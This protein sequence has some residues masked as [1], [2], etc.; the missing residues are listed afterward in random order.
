MRRF[1]GRAKFAALAVLIFVNSTLV[2]RAQG[3]SIYRLP[4][5]TRIRLKMDAEINSRVSS[6]NDTFITF[7]AHPVRN[8]GVVVIPENAVVEGRVTRVSPASGGSHAGSLDVVF[9]TLKF[10][11]STRSID[12]I[13]TKPFRSASSNTFSVLSILG[14]AAAGALVGAANSPRGVLIGAGV[15]A[16][17][18]T[19]AALLR[20]GKDVKIR[21]G[22]EF[23]IEL[24]K[25][26][27]LPVL[28]Y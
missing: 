27:V 1:G 7:V 19:G 2:V 12:G 13:A 4:A 23:E 21:R 18:G 24:K 3:D 17:A 9:E 8:R 16:G 10:A 5:G 28:D 25:E 26:V 20:K 22:E 14:G 11:G 6:A 15:G